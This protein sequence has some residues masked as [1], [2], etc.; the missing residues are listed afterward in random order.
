MDELTAT[1]AAIAPSHSGPLRSQRLGLCP[2]VTVTESAPPRPAGDEVAYVWVASGLTADLFPL[3]VD[4]AR[5]LFEWLNQRA[6]GE[7]AARVLAD[8]AL[9]GRDVVFSAEDRAVVYDE[10]R[11]RRQKPPWSI[12]VRNGLIDLY[13]ELLVEFGEFGSVET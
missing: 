12:H 6:D 5:T 9:D 2:S 10:L 4:C 1:T 3:D 11:L 13:F 7:G 8:A